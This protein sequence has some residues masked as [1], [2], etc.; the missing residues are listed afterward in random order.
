MP[1]SL[2]GLQ[3][4]WDARPIGLR[5]AA[6]IAVVAVAFATVAS[7]PRIP[8]PSSY[9][10]FAG[11]HVSF[12]GVPHAANVLSNAAMAVPGLAGLWLLL[13]Q[14][15][16][17]L[18]HL[19]T[20]EALCWAAT[21]LCMLGGE[22]EGQRVPESAGGPGRREGQPSGQAPHHVPLPEPEPLH[23]Y[24]PP[25]SSGGRQRSLPPRAQQ[26]HAGLGQA[27]HGGWAWWPGHSRG[28]G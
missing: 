28:C 9:H 13:A 1:G 18:S 11:D 19:S 20:A 3:R 25:L 2:L 6:E 21:F 5:F 4:W 27:G 12:L 23:L 7:L 15:R 10:S 22:Q 24:F 14:R 17:A 26:R 8:Q 16:R